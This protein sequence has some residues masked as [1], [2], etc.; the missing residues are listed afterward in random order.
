M[1]NN[2]KNTYKAVRWQYYHLTFLILTGVGLRVYSDWTRQRH[3]DG[4][5]HDALV[6]TH[7]QIVELYVEKY[8]RVIYHYICVYILR[9]TVL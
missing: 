7:C 1:Q 2:N 3:Y 8:A 5:K 6:L 9:N 4:V